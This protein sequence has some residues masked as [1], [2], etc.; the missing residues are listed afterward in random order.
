MGIS[1][2]SIRY[3][4]KVPD[5]LLSILDNEVKNWDFEL[6]KYS[7]DPAFIKHKIKPYF[8]NHPSEFN[9]SKENSHLKDIIDWC[10]Q[11]VGNEYRPARCFLNLLEQKQTFPIHVDTL[12]L[13]LLS[14]RLHIPITNS[15]NCE[16][17][18]Y[19][20]ENDSWIKLVN[21][22]KYGMLYELDNIN[23]HSVIN[24]GNFPRINFILDVIEES[25]IKN[26]NLM[27][28]NIN[29]VMIFQNL[30]LNGIK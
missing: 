3:I 15:N 13:H 20:K 4:K 7:Y 18:T 11:Q 16:Y 8:L 14:K 12:E 5:N 10:C 21:E 29:Q 6:E 23:P 2:P 17:I 22:M 9:L 26:E 28:K 19:K 1:L 25:K 24:N 27:K 30:R